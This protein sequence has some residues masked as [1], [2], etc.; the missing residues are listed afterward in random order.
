MPIPDFIYAGTPQE[1]ARYTGEVRP[2]RRGVPA[3]LTVDQLKQKPGAKVLTYGE[4]TER[5][6]YDDMCDA[7]IAIGGEWLA[8]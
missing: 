1:Y 5:G 2:D 6:D 3:L 7:I 8:P 4:F